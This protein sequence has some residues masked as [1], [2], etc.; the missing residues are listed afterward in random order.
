MGNDVCGVGRAG[1]TWITSGYW[2]WITSGCCGWITCCCG[3]NTGY[4]SELLPRKEIAYIIK[5]IK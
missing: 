2:C 4:N 5:N 3:I 1:T